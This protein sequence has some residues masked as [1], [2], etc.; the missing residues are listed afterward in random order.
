MS[1]KW[2]EFGKL[3][4]YAELD[5][6]LDGREYSHTNYFHYTKLSNIESILSNNYFLLSCVDGF[7]DRI[8]KEQFGDEKKQKE[9]YSICFSTGVNENLSLWYLYGGIS[10]KG[11]RI[12][13]TKKA[14]E[15]LIKKG[16]YYLYEYDENNKELVKSRPIEL[17]DGINAEF[18]FKDIIYY[19]EQD[20]RISLKY[21]NMTNYIFKDL[22]S[23]KEKHKKF[24][25]GL[26][27][28]YEKE[29]RFVVHLTGEALKL[30]KNNADK[31][32]VVVLR[33]DDKFKK[34]MN[35][36]V[37]PEINSLNDLL[38]NPDYPNIKQKLFDSSKVKL[39][40]YHGQINMN[41]CDKCEYKK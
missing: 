29:T 8:D 32:Y 12:Q 38:N 2:N 3:T 26:I 22:P 6:Y 20:E 15:E 18:L 25:K 39:S 33:F 28:Y 41:L 9:Y 37:A 24:L 4:K 16:K 17:T 36:D 30:V 40:N 23:L 34:R 11:G 5:E 31:K 35:I 14:V 27:W 10:G 7:N 1:Y 19:S 21:N 13:M